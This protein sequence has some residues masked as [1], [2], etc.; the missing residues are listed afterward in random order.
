[1]KKEGGRRNERGPLFNLG[2]THDLQ[3]KVMPTLPREKKRQKRLTE[4]MPDERLRG[5]TKVYSYREKRKSC[6]KGGAP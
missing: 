5:T 1:M 6:S 4:P 3:K 2:K